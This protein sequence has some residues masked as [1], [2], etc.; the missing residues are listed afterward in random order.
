MSCA[1][2]W[3]CLDPRSTR[4]GSY[5][6]EPDS[7]AQDYHFDIGRDTDGHKKTRSLR[8]FDAKKRAVLT[9]FAALT[10]RSLPAIYRML[11]LL[12]DQSVESQSRL[13]LETMTRQLEREY[14]VS[15]TPPPTE[16]F[17]SPTAEELSEEWE[18]LMRRYHLSDLHPLDKGPVPWP[19][20]GFESDSEWQNLK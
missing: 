19:R 4:P 11:Q 1:A 7:Y 14:M 16:C 5:L 13:S 17:E 3:I 6:S 9:R 10:S 8:F 15:S 2:A 18:F 12:Q 20:P